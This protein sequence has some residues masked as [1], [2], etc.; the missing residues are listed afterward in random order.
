MTAI[1]CPRCE[2]TFE[3]QATTATRC[4]VCRSVVH[5]GGSAGR[6]SSVT[7]QPTAAW[8]VAGPCRL[9]LS[10]ESVWTTLWWWTLTGSLMAA[11]WWGVI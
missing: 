1:E 6:R 8:R 2:T 10:C 3:T 7:Q 9:T 4:R 5:V 11:S